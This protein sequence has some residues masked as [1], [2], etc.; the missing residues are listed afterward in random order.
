MSENA[1]TT[2][3]KALAINLDQLKYGTIAEIGAGQEV[4]R[5]FFQAGAAAGTIAKTMS[6]YDMGFSDA[7]YGAD[8]DGRY[9]SRARCERMLSQEYDLIISRIKSSRPEGSRFFAFTNT[10]AA[11]GF[12]RRDE[13]HGWIGVRLPQAPEMEPDN[14]VLHVRML[15]D[16]NLEQ[17]EA[18]GILGVNLI[19]GAFMHAGDPKRLMRSLLDNL[20]RGRIEID[21]V[22]FSGPSLGHLD[23]RKMAIELVEAK[24]TPAILFGPNCS[25]QIPADVL[26]KKSTLVMRSNFDPSTDVEMARFDYAVKRFAAER[27]IDPDQIV[28]LAEVTMR[29][30]TKTGNVETTNYIERIEELA[31]RGFHV[32]ISEFVS[33]YFVRQYIAHYTS[34]PV[35]I[36][37]DV[38]GFQEIFRPEV[39]DGLDGGILEGLGKLF[40]DGTTA[41]VYPTVEDGKRL[42]LDAM[43]FA[44]S[45]RPLSVYLRG[46]G[47][48]VS[49]DDF[50]QSA[51]D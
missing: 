9:V 43:E 49:A 33:N 44:E 45:L 32:L 48:L 47:R 15:D 42:T 50:E 12:R 35:G 20:K 27:G 30:L 51:G 14:I 1:L 3:E 16:T 36:V 26:Y 38:K 13:C 39:Y 46:L 4:A 5:W 8:D 22:E 28:R 23:N 34:A 41:Y 19:Y 10:V 7:I 21:L 17:Q 40:P 6:A 18:L 24:L 29:E 37:T 11:Q 25:V 31:K 2:I